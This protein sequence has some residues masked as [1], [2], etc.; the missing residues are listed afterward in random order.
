MGLTSRRTQALAPMLLRSALVFVS[1]AK[2]VLVVVA[3][4]LMTEVV[5]QG[6]WKVKLAVLR[7]AGIPGVFFITNNA[8]IGFG[9]TAGFFMSGVGRGWVRRIG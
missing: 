8:F 2:L 7:R 9:A 4:C 5:V 1:L 3:C 6:S